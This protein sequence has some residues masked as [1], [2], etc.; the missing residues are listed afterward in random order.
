MNASSVANMP[1]L[2]YD[3]ANAAPPFATSLT[4]KSPSPSRHPQHRHRTT[5]SIRGRRLH[6]RQ[7]CILGLR[8][9]KRVCSS[10]ARARP[11]SKPASPRRTDLGEACRAVGQ[12]LR[13]RQA[14]EMVFDGDGPL[15]FRPTFD[16]HQW[17]W[18]ARFLVDCLPHRANRHTVEIVKLATESRA[19]AAADQAAGR[20]PLRTTAPRGILHFYPATGGIRERDRRR[21]LMAQVWLQSHP[22]STPNA[23]SRSSRR[24]PNSR[25]DI[26]ARL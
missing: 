10:T 19:L 20:H 7:H 1:S 21:E 22:S 16:L 11:G 13:R 5:T 26:V 18:I 23:W 8:Q 17:L 2:A 3:V 25:A 9:G 6:R 24:S 14:H 4:A 15:L 12:T